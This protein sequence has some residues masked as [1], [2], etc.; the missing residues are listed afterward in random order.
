IFTMRRHS[1]IS[2]ARLTCSPSNSRTFLARPCNGARR[3][4]RCGLPARSSKQRNIV[5]AKKLFFPRIVFPVERIGRE[6]ILKTAAWGYDGKGQ[7]S[8]ASRDLSEVWQTRSA[9]E[10]ILER[11]IDFE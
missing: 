8:I 6:S 1:A 3:N 2:A 10:L 9:D 7:Q 5:C 11:A 4:A